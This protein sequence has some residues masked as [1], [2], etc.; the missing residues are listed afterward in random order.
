MQSRNAI[1][2]L[3]LPQLLFHIVSLLIVG[4]LCLSDLVN[5]AFGYPIGFMAILF[6]LLR[7]LFKRYYLDYVL[8]I[9]ACSHFYY[10]NNHGGLWNYVNVAALL[11]YSFV[12]PWWER[13]SNLSPFQKTVLGGLFLFNTLGLFFVAESSIAGRFEGFMVSLSYGLLFLFILQLPPKIALF[14]RVLLVLAGLGLWSLV[15]ALNQKAMLLESVSPLLPKGNGDSLEI[16]GWEEYENKSERVDGPFKDFELF[17]EYMSLLYALFLPILISRTGQYF[18]LNAGIP[19]LAVGGA[20]L[21]VLMT[22]TR[23]SILLLVVISFFYLLYY[24]SHFI[25]KPALLIAIGVFVSFII[26]I[27]PYIGLDYIFE[28]FNELDFSRLSSGSAK[29]VEAINRG[30]TYQAG[31]ERL[32]AKDWLIGYGYGVSEH[33]SMAFFGIPNSEMRDYHNLYLSLPIMLGW[34]G[35]C[36]FVALLVSHFYQTITACR[37][38]TQ[39]HLEA[40]ILGM[41]VLWVV[42]FINEFKIQAIR[43]PNYLMLIWCW[44]GFSIQA[45]RLSSRT[46]KNKA[47]LNALV[48]TYTI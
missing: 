32:V 45:N 8:I 31:L 9:F 27:G 33:Y 13:S 38:A 47:A 18:K 30:E 7:L 42:F 17:A 19:L 15:I 4:H 16:H 43:E 28:R 22:V 2:L 1:T 29:S 46:V 36:L 21:C 37:V 3:S 26:I 14:N 40:L 34:I 11:L 20:F 35:T 24:R 5:P 23:S 25:R 10:G 39:P 44:L 6:L 48:P 41:S 12:E